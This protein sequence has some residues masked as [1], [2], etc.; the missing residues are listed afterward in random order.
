MFE[1]LELRQLMSVTACFDG[2]TLRSRRGRRR[3]LCRQL[4]QRRGKNLF[5]GEGGDD[6]LYL[7]ATKDTVDGGGG[8]DTVFGK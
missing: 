7:T 5:D 8:N 6:T 2:H 4:S 3:S 1:T